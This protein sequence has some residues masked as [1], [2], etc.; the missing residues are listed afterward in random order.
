MSAGVEFCNFSSEDGFVEAFGNV[1]E[2]TQK[3]RFL[4]SI[5]VA[6]EI[7]S[8][9]SDLIRSEQIRSD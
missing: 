4:L 3:A 1:V 6:F 9:K 7:L 5:F 2:H 8:R